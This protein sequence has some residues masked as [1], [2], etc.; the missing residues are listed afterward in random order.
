MRAHGQATVEAALL[1]LLM[2][3]VVVLVAQ[4][5]FWLHA[6]NVAIA[7]AQEGARAATA[8]GSDPAEGVAVGQALLDAGLG[9]SGGAQV[10]LNVTED[11]TSVTMTAK[12][13]WPLLLGSPGLFALPISAEARVLKDTWT[14]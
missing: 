12:G 2:G 9:P 4:T 5:A 14:P 11:A 10:Q 1:A 7:A 8:Q 3:L 13:S 6:E